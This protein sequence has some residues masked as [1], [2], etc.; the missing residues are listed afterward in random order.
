MASILVLKKLW[1]AYF[2]A[3]ALDFTT[4]NLKNNSTEDTDKTDLITMY[5][6]TEKGFNCYSGGA[7]ATRIEKTKALADYPL[8]QKIL[9]PCHSRT[10]MNCSEPYCQKCM[11]GLFTLDYYNKLDNMKEVFDIEK[12]RKNHIEYLISLIRLKDNEFFVELFEMMNEKYPEEIKKAKKIFEERTKP[13]SRHDY[14][15]M[16][17]I[18]DI[19]CKLMTVNNL[20]ENI[21]KFFKDKEFNKIYKIG[22]SI[23]GDK[24]VEMIKEDFLFVDRLTGTLSECDGGFILSTDDAQIKFAE[25]NLKKQGCNK[26][27]TIFDIYNEIVKK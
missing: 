15:T 4:F 26:Y 9:H 21:V 13:V 6:L 8:A 23:A 10:K 5:T 7:K 1:K 24:I 2:L 11:R 25:T 22:G 17:R 20:K 19:V 18:Y 16:K 14:N 12:Y 3:S 27:Y